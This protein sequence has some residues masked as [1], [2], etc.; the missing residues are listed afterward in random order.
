M[1]SRRESAV[2]A[3]ATTRFRIPASIHPSSSPR[4][5]LHPGR[6]KRRV[7]LRLRGSP[8]VRRGSAAAAH[9]GFARQATQTSSLRFVARRTLS[10]IDHP[11]AK[12]FVDFDETYR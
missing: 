11:Q 1:G 6:L 7:R 4:G 2:Q 3:G 10:I 8:T 5:I 12:N 9:A